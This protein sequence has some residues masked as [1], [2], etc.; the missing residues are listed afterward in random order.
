MAVTI[1]VGTN[2]WV[3]ETEANA[4]AEARVDSANYWVAG[5]ALN[6]AALVQAYDEL[7]R[8]GRWSLSASATAATAIKNAQCGHA[9]FLLIH[10]PDRA[11]REGL[12]S[13]LVVEAGVV[14]EKYDKRTTR[15]STSN[16]VEGLLRPYLAPGSSGFAIFDI[17]RDEEQTTDY[18]APGNLERD[19]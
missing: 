5:A 11:I 7:L 18:N 9:L 19:A 4:W 14:K 6:K 3:T 15:L 12:Q 13:Q 2:S 16:Y 10:E 8:C 1:T 17:E